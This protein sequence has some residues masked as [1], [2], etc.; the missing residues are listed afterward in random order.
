M[1]KRYNFKIEQTLDMISLY[2]L[3]VSTKTIA[4]LYNINNVTL[5]K[6][7]KKHEFFFLMQFRSRSETVLITL[8]RRRTVPEGE[9]IKRIK[10]WKQTF[11]RE[12]LIDILTTFL[13]T[14]GS[15]DY[16]HGMIRLSSSDEIMRKIFTDLL[17]ELNLEPRET[18]DNRNGIGV[19]FAR[20]NRVRKMLDEVY[21]RTPTT[22]HQPQR[23]TENWEIYLKQKQPSLLWLYERPKELKELCFRIAMSTDGSVFSCRR[24]NFSVGPEL[25]LICFHP[26][27]LKDWHNISKSLDL[28]MYLSNKRLRTRSV[29]TAQ[30]FLKIGGFIEGIK[31]CSKGKSKR[32]QGLEKQ[33]RLKN[34]LRDYN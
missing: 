33:K 6:H 13:L 7:L 11:G 25:N 23:G 1:K 34:L 27:L 9:D 14:D 4:K 12:G 2:Q 21:K 5:W 10:V 8:S 16:G 17:N 29:K 20:N 26:T 32:Y 31:I 3:G 22:K 15:A 30:K 19:I 28:K 18:K 24:R